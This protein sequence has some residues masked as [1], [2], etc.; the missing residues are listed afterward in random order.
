MDD[1]FTDVPGLR[2]GHAHDG[3]AIT[4]VTVIVPDQPAVAGVD[5]RGGAPGTRD[6]EALDPTCLVERIHGIVL[7]GGSVFG[8]AAADAVTLWLSARGIGLPI[9][10]QPVPVVPAAILFDLRNGGDKAWGDEPPYYG[11]GRAACD[12]LGAPD[13]SGRVGAGHGARAGASWGG[14]G[15]ASLP[16][17]Q[18]YRVGALIAVNSFGVVGDTGDDRAPIVLPKAPIAAS[19]TTIGVVAT[20]APLTKAQAKRIAMMA[21]DGLARAIRPI[22]TPFDG[23][24]LFVLS[25]APADAVPID[26]LTITHLGTGAADAVLRAVRRAVAA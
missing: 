4:G 23:D 19:N 3:T 21:H 11:L 1:R 24:T 13:I 14:I 6:T 7:A 17:Q 26:P 16:V 10:D 25:T 22:H 12:S 8:L 18:G 9:A 2:V 5:V 15:S 20:N